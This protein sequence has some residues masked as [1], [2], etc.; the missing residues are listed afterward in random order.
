MVIFLFIIYASGKLTYFLLNKF[1]MGQDD[2]QSNDQKYTQLTSLKQKQ[3]PVGNKAE[4]QVTLLT[5][6][7]L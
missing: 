1:V 3:Q 2:G 6:K 4:D 7:D 5:V